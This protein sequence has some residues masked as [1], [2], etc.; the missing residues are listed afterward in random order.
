MIS[1]THKLIFYTIGK[2]GTTSI[3]DT[4]YMQG[5]NFHGAKHIPPFYFNLVPAQFKYFKFSFIRN[6]WD[7][8]I[9][10]WNF[11]INHYKAS[12]VYKK[13]ISFDNFLKLWDMNRILTNENIDLIKKED[14]IYST[15]RI[16]QIDWLSDNEGNLMVDFVGKFENLQKDFDVICEK[17][18]IPQIN[19]SVSNKFF[20]KHYREYYTEHTKEVVR[21]RFNKDIEYGGY[22]F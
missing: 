13:N 14:K 9:S 21:E 20:H 4:L 1:D 12:P 6:P 22:E 7:K 17:I 16:S 11:H 5:C 18:D 10:T 19:L 2:T 3:M 8:I 15:D